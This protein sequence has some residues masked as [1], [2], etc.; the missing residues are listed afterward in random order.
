MCIER[1]RL[2]NERER[3]PSFLLL[4]R[5]L[6]FWSTIERQSCLWMERVFAEKEIPGTCEFGESTVN[7]LEMVSSFIPVACEETEG[8][9]ACTHRQYVHDLFGCLQVYVHPKGRGLVRYLP[10]YLQKVLDYHPRQMRR[11]PQP[12]K[13]TRI[14]TPFLC[15]K[16]YDVPR[17]LLHSD[18]QKLHAA[19]VQRETHHSP[20]ILT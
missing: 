17:V 11:L 16:S 10:F 19:P 15:P 5:P 3:S 1:K 13:E 6:S 12:D 7:L 9:H 14:G 4:D 20:K 2:E 8:L 18:P